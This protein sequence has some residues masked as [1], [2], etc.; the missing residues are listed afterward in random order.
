MIAQTA[1]ILTYCNGDGSKSLERWSELRDYLDVW[2]A[3]VPPSFKAIHVEE[4]SIEAG[5]LFPIR[6]FANDCHSL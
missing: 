6:W 2:R 4:A 5:L 1:D 3:A